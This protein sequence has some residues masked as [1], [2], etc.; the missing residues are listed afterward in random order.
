M[1]YIAHAEFGAWADIDPAEAIMMCIRVAAGEL[2]WFNEA[3]SKLEMDEVVVTESSRT[4]GSGP[5]GPVD[6]RTN[7]NRATLNILIRARQ[8]ATDRLFRY[9]EKALSLGLEE[10]RVRMAE[11]WGQLMGR[12]LRGVMEDL[13]LTPEQA[14]R[15]PDIVRNHLQAL[16]AAA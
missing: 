2:L 3:V 4:V 12:M 10:R 1:R 5:E 15:A 8:D 13:V 7:T 14:K 6:M 9:S 11:Q 16:E